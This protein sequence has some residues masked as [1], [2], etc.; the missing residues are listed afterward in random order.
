M[1]VQ[2]TMPTRLDLRTSLRLRLEDTGAT[3]LWDDAFLNDAIA[4][5]IRRYAIHQPKQ[6]ILST[7]VAAGATRIAL[8]VNAVDPTRILRI[9]D[10]TGAIVPRIRSGDP[11]EYSGQGWRPFADGITLAEGAIAGTWVIEHLAPRAVPTDDVAA[12]D[13]LAGDDWV[14]LRI[15]YALALDRRATEEAKRGDG[16]A[17]PLRSLAQ[18]AWEMVDRWAVPVSRRARLAG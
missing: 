13:I 12:L 18:A 5:A 14:V 7:S 17:V 11:P 8:T 10:S 9:F 16:S 1:E 15:A 6:V 4:D 2:P 3:V